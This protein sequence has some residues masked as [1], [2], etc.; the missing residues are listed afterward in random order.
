MKDRVERAC[1]AYL[2]E[3]LLRQAAKGPLPGWQQRF[4]AVVLIVDISGFTPLAEALAQAG[5]QGAE[6]LSSLLNQ[7]F[8]QI[9]ELC[10]LY[11]G[12]T[13][14]FSGDAMTALFMPL[15]SEG[16]QLEPAGRRALACAQSIQ[17]YVGQTAVLHTTQ[18]TFPLQVRIG[19]GAGETVTAVLGSV[20]TGLL[21][22]LAGPSRAAA[23][24]ALLRAR[25]GE[26]VLDRQVQALLPAEVP[27][28]PLP[29]GCAR[30][31][32]GDPAPPPAS[33]AA[34]ETLVPPERRPELAAFLPPVLLRRIQTAGR[35]F[36]G[37]HR[38]VVILFVGFQGP[39]LQAGRQLQSY[40][41]AV[42]AIVQ[43]YDG[44]LNDVEVGDKG[45]LLLILFGAPNAHEDDGERALHCA[46]DLQERI[47][48][49][50]LGVASQRIGISSGLVFVGPLGS[51]ERWTYTAIGDE[52]NLA[53]RLMEGATWGQIVVSARLQHAVSGRGQFRPLGRT[54]IKG[55]LE[56]VP[57]FELQAMERD[58]R[59]PLVWEQLYQ[60][61]MVGREQEWAQIQK[62]AQQALAGKG[63]VILLE[64]EAGVGKSRLA[65]KVARWWAGRGG[66][67]YSADSLSYTM[68]SP[69]HPFQQL[70][71]TMFELAPDRP[72]QE[73]VQHLK[74]ALSF[75]PG[76]LSVRLPLL[77][78]ILGLPIPDNPFTEHLQGPERK[79]NLS[80]LILDIVRHQA[81][82]APTLL[83]FED[84][85]W[86]DGPSLELLLYIARNIASH[87]VLV[88]PIHRPL[89]KPQP[90]PYRQLAGLPHSQSLRLHALSPAGSQ[91]LARLRLDLPAHVRLPPELLK[92]LERAQGN[93]FFIEEILNTLQDAGIRLLPQ[94]G[95]CIVQGDLEHLQVPQTVQ[96]VVQARLDQLDEGSQLT[97][98]VAS[99]IGRTVPYSQLQGIYPLEVDEAELSSQLAALERVD[100]LLL[101]Q[102]QERI[103]FFKHIIT[104]E[105]AY[106]SLLFSQRR[107]LH[108]ALARYLEDV[109]VD[110]LD[111]VTDLLAHHYHL[112][113][114]G[115]KAWVYL[116][117]AG[118]RAARAF[119]NRE[120]LEYYRQARA[121]LPQDNA[122]AHWD[123]LQRL[124]RVLQQLGRHEEQ[125]R[126][127]QEMA[128]LA[129]GDE[130]RQAY[131]LY[132]QGHMLL[133]WGQYCDSL[134]R[135]EEAVV[136]AERC[137]DDS[138]AGR[139]W[140]TICRAYW[141]QYDIER[142]HESLQRARQCFQRGRDPQGEAT[143]LGTLG[144][145]YL[146]IETQ[147]ERALQIYRQLVEHY[148]ALRR[149]RDEA[150]QRINV[151]IALLALGAAEETIE[152]VQPARTFFERSGDTF[153]LG[154]VHFVLGH[155]HLRRH[156]EGPALE[157]ARR[158][159]ALL[160][161]VQNRN[162]II[163]AE[164][165]F[166]RV[167]LASGQPG[168]A[169][170]H[171][172]QAS[173]LAS[174]AGQ[175]VDAF[176]YRSFEALAL[177]QLG[178]AQDALEISQEV[179]SFLQTYGQRVDDI[180]QLYHHHFHIVR[181]VQGLQAARPYLQRAHELLQEM[182]A[183]IQDPGLRRSFVQGNPWNQQ[184]VHDWQRTLDAVK[185]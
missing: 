71:A 168:P 141:L 170:E 46:L 159:V 94:N 81:G 165:L 9:I 148:K 106:E 27:L 157:A 158:S 166:G 37:E 146:S 119:S 176:H 51:V 102:P 79:R 128:W 103:F 73:R 167:L 156:K 154:M 84:I 109:H 124:E 139:C 175:K 3:Y 132:H 53:S 130:Q 185:E 145:I 83:L 57:T 80:G 55:K 68:G 26:I 179:V 14:Q 178:R 8:S 24:E 13:A 15:D 107:A 161:E 180:P 99:V 58:N 40:V 114:N 38:R 155:A 172:R 142:M 5:R 140:N 137:G 11:G 19:L 17:Q 88:L 41:A 75:M 30:A 32:A 4:A 2:P 131:V 54:V 138:L 150:V 44:R 92:L 117:R 134:S 28:Q 65:G 33:A 47:R 98:K 182:A 43:R 56:A 6:E 25:P 76:D 151:C 91:A 23:V 66:Q 152:T 184:I 153:M 1:L 144:T 123:Y 63:Q 59:A 82:V 72:A 74:A 160:R 183:E 125:E 21:H 86:M 118:N 181:Q 20:E 77:A 60:D 16:K 70:L 169:L 93:P 69:Y 7:H 129:Q 174:S 121:W 52:M 22:L 122:E 36:V 48:P 78:D 171:F 34:A 12:D 62:L 104:R 49:A 149:P 45:S 108:Q 111:Q 116:M 147:Y 173:E 110:E 61:E 136:L 162:F 164:G 87:P 163:E 115:E 133:D 127:L 177:L 18:G 39:D 112:G 120:A 42:Q 85:H 95:S 113:G 29:G 35:A 100:L 89:D 143:A 90:A 10:R 105:V 97:L 67:L 50:D 64:G 126:V 31:P 96:G 101:E 135:L